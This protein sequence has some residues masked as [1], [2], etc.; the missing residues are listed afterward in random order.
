MIL[1]FQR[2]FP[3]I[4]QDSVASVL[5]HEDQ[6]GWFKLAL[7]SVGCRQSGK[8][9]FSFPWTISSGTQAAGTEGGGVS[10]TAQE[11]LGQAGNGGAFA[12]GNDGDVAVDSADLQAGTWKS[13]NSKLRRWRKANEARR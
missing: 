11:R 3:Q 6:A 13:L 9:Q 1:S 4:P 5:V 12:S 2:C 8:R 7:F 10:A